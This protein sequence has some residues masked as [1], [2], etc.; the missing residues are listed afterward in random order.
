MDS[1]TFQYFKFKPFIFICCRFA[2]Q[3][4]RSSFCLTKSSLICEKVKS[5]TY[6]F[7]KNL[8]SKKAGVE[9]GKVAKIIQKIKLF[10]ILFLILTL[11]APLNKY[12][13]HF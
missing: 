9:G 13:T 1:F 12:S 7:L 10:F 11:I 5:F 3:L 6:Y 4:E 8:T 2:T